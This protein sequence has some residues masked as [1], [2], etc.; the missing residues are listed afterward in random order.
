MNWIEKIMKE[1]L[2]HGVACVGRQR[3]V[4]CPPLPRVV[5]MAP[6]QEG[7]GFSDLG[8]VEKMHT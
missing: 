8:L 2:I 1:E 7:S 6:R 4:Q 5:K 3:P